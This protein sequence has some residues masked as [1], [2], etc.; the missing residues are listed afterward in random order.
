MPEKL[1][2]KVGSLNMS[3]PSH[4][5]HLCVPREYDRRNHG[6]DWDVGAVCEGCGTVTAFENRPTN[7]ACP[8]CGRMWPF[9]CRGVGCDVLIE[10]DYA[11]G[12]WYEPYPY[13]RECERNR[14]AEGAEV[15]FE[16]IPQGT[17][18]NAIDGWRRAKHRVDAE[19][20]CKFWLKHDL[21]RDYGNMTGLYF[22]GDVG[23]GK[24]TI[25][26]R[27]AVKA[28]RSG[29]VRSFIWVKEY[30]LMMATKAMGYDAKKEAAALFK[31]VETAELA[32]IDEMF[33]VS[34]SL[35]DH[36][37]V[38][39]G[40]AIA[41]RFEDRLPTIVTSNHDPAWAALYD[42]RVNS[43]FNGMFNV[44]KLDGPDLRQHFGGGSR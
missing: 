26:A 1:Y 42:V 5:A 16:E 32:V 9:R 40:Q 21:G 18:S 39:I 14:L 29:R 28:I 30:D 17:L 34:E 31:R 15:M 13:C 22:Y 23:T 33:A 20:E 4:V 24:T 35:T 12:H 43:R 44:M 3:V 11:N 36:A 41:K 27:C 7:N 2:V 6:I 37:K 10:P 25:A 19:K 38:M 8:A